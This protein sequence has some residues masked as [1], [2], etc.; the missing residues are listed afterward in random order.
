MA[1]EACG[2]D[3]IKNK[4]LFRDSGSCVEMEKLLNTEDLMLVAE[5]ALCQGEVNIALE[6]SKQVLA[7]AEETEA[8]F[9]RDSAI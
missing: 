6:Y 8:K 5:H 4:S 2:A 7:I 3:V 1:L 9:L